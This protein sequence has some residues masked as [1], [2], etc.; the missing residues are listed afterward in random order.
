VD[1]L[2]Q[3]AR[4]ADVINRQPTREQIN[5]IC[6]SSA[7]TGGPVT[8]CESTSIAAIID[9]RLRNLSSTRVRGLDLK[10]DRSFR[11]NLGAFDL[12]LNGGY[13]RSFRQAASTSS[14]MLSILDTVGNPQSL[15][16]RATADWYQRA[17]DRDGFGA[18][19]SVDHFGAYD[20]VQTVLPGSVSALTTVDL[21]ASYRTASGNYPFDDVEFSLNGS[22]ILNKAPP[23]VDRSAGYDQINALPYGRVISFSVQ[24]RW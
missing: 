5:S 6:E 10:I 2:F 7:Y 1:I 11:T 18:S 4:W 13:V 23:F 15:R 24:K 21:R 8:Q 14:P 19:L 20:D 3:E 17:F 22:N 9:L 16:V 12:G